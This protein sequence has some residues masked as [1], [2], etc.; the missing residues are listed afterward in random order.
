MENMD[1]GRLNNVPKLVVI[2]W[3][4][5]LGVPPNLSTQIVCP[6]AKKIICPNCQTIWDFDET[7]FI[8]RPQ[9]VLSP[10]PCPLKEFRVINQNLN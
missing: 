10:I 7:G 3:S 1:K 9:S 4:K 2:N 6:N 8:R 5:A